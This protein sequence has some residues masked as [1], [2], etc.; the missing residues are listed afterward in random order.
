[1][2]L[3]FASETK[4]QSTTF[5][6]DFQVPRQL[7]LSI[8]Q[9]SWR[10]T[11]N[12]SSI[13]TAEVYFTTAR[14]CT[15]RPCVA[16]ETAASVWTG[17]PLRHHPRSSTSRAIIFPIVLV[18]MGGINAQGVITRPRSLT[19]CFDCFCLTEVVRMLEESVSLEVSFILRG[20][21]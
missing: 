18:P 14:K 5:F 12:R 13:P 2:S 7:H 9:G 1:M 3:T 21:H 20:V 4:E 10:G 19:S 11:P 6:A 15:E 17:H 16:C 8:C